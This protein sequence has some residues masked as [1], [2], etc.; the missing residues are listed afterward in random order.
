MIIYGNIIAEL[1]FRLEILHNFKDIIPFFT[2]IT[3][4]FFEIMTDTGDCDGQDIWFLTEENELF[5]WYPVLETLIFKESDV[6]DFSIGEGGIVAIIKKDNEVYTRTINAN[7]WERVSY[8]E[9]F[10]H[11]NI[12][13]CNILEI[14]TIDSHNHLIKVDCLNNHYYVSCPFRHDVL[15]D[16]IY[17]HLWTI[18][19]LYQNLHL[20]KLKFYVVDT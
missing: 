4:I 3:W 10:E 15:M 9:N 13:V 18:V 20:S 11:K 8:Y 16:Y 12:S 5:H 17:S 7:E 14:Y 6:L 2:F 19:L 1:G